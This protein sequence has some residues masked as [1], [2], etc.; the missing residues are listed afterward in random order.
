MTF[1]I[2]KTNGITLA[3][4]A[5][6]TINT[7]AAS[8]TLI[9]KNFPTYGQLLNQNLV[10][11]LENF[12][13]TTSP[14]SA[15][16][17]Q[18][19][20]DS[21]SNTLQYYR[22]GTSSNYWQ[23][24]TNIISSSSTPLNFQQNDFWWDTANQQLKYYDNFQWITIGPQTTNDGLTRVSGTNSFIVQIG[25]NNV[26][27]V[28]AYGRVSAAYN[29]VMQG[30]GNSTSSQVVGAGLLYPT[31]W[32]PNV[33]VNIGGYFNGNNGVFTCPV[34]G[35]YQVSATIVSLGYP[36]TTVTSTQRMD[37]QKNQS[38]TG[39]GARVKH[40]NQVSSSTLEFP[41]TASGYISCNANDTLQLIV[42]ADSGGV[43]DYLDSTMSIRLVA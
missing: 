33:K 1:Y 12:A 9:G 11:M 32:I 29:P 40:E 8:I 14:N 22:A 34:N 26:F 4:I 6:G 38:N 2:N 24:L 39:I 23:T 27:T 35:I 30:T 25:G 28:D 19:W 10:S 15:L 17:G 13:S 42:A 20:Y 37:W 3:T 7:T 21:S 36:S 16:T 18:L 43:I 41:M 31:T 5:D